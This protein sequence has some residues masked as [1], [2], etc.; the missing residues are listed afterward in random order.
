MTS[1]ANDLVP[2]TEE[3]EDCKPMPPPHESRKTSIRRDRDRRGVVLVLVLV[4]VVL[5]TLSALTFSEL[6]LAERKGALYSLRREQTRL[7]ATSGIEGLRVVLL[8]DEETL[9]EQG[10]LYHNPEQLQGVPVVEGA[11]SMDLGRF[12]VL[13]P[14]L[15]EEGYYAGLRYGLADESARMNLH[16]VMQ[17]EEESEGAGRDLLMGLPG[18]DET[19]ADAIL[20]WMD[21]DDETREFGYEVDHYGTLEPPYAPRNGICE[22]IDE[23]LLVEGVTGPL[24]FGADW[25]RNGVIDSGEPDPRSLTFENADNADGSLDLGLQAYLTLESKESITDISGEKKIHLNKDDLQSLHQELQSALGN[26]QWADYIIG[27]RQ[28]GPSEGG[29]EGGGG[30]G[31]IDF[32]TPGETRIH[33]V[34][35]LVGGATEIRYQ[36]QEEATMLP[37][38]FSEDIGTMSSYLPQLLESTTVYEEPPAG[39]INL[40]QAPRAVLLAIPGIEEGTVEAILAER[41][42]DPMEAASVEEMQYE[43]WPLTTGVI[44]LEEM[45]TILPYVCSEGAVRR[46]Q[47][48]GRFDHDSPVVRLEVLLDTTE[49]P[50]N[51]LRVR[52]LSHLGPGYPEELLIPGS[53]GIDASAYGVESY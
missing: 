7:L 25:N 47:V 3:I 35:D 2:G 37:S 42:L 34:L 15:D 32:S 8:Q 10:G 45:K 28:N 52:D 16:T 49:Q 31:Q 40:N 43:T 21:E 30:G 26:P 38:P 24:L 44:D 5:L 33:S 36:G 53:S 19:I 29:G 14:R 12:S 4:M 41:I 1:P 50:A 17:L 9:Y 18:V 51:I 11:D 46:A 23:L 22:S 27:Y 6:M 20:D 39:R 13:V 48:V